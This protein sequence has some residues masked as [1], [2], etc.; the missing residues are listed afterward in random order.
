MMVD[1][2]SVFDPRFKQMFPVHLLERFYT[3]F[4]C[5]GDEKIEYVYGSANE[6]DGGVF[7]FEARC[8]Y[9]LNGEIEIY[10]LNHELDTHLIDV[11]EVE[12]RLL[13]AVPRKIKG[14]SIDE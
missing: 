9:S 12:N 7:I 14:I 11:K 1:V 2:N 4:L 6:M 13:N 8:D 5:L 3:D 10:D